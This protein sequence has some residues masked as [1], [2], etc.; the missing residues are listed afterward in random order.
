MA[1]GSSSWSTPSQ[2]CC[3]VPASSR[4]LLHGLTWWGRLCLV[5]TAVVHVGRRGHPKPYGPLL[6]VLHTWLMPSTT[7]PKTAASCSRCSGSM[8]QTEMALWSCKSLCNCAARSSLGSRTV[9][10]AS[11]RQCWMR[12]WMA[13]CPLMSFWLAYMLLPRPWMQSTGVTHSSSKCSTQH[14]WPWLRTWVPSGMP[15][16]T[17]TGMETDFWMQQSSRAFSRTCLRAYLRSSYACW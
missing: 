6:R 11:C 16:D 17:M 8:T 2:V 10:Y 12:M 1:P 7:L 4:T 13:L 14:L 5:A 15:S 9:T 3:T